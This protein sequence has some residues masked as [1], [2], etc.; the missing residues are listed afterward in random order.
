[1]RH[2]FSFDDQDLD[3][4]EPKVREALMR[5]ASQAAAAEKPVPDVRYGP[6]EIEIES[7]HDGKERQAQFRERF[8]SGGFVEIPDRYL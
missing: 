3:Q 5:L 8:R 6:R 2:Q 7:R 4:F 1:M